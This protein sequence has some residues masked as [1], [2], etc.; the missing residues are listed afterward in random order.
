MKHDVLL[1]T[2][3]KKCNHGRPCVSVSQL[4]RFEIQCFASL[5]NHQQGLARQCV[6]GLPVPGR[7]DL[8]PCTSAAGPACQECCGIFAITS[9]HCI[10][11][12][13]QVHSCAAFAKGV[14][15]NAVIRSQARWCVFSASLQLSEHQ[16]VVNALPRWHA[17]CAVGTCFAHHPQRAR[18]LNAVPC[19][20]S[21]LLSLCQA[22]CLLA[23]AC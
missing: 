8:R 11:K 21:S 6:F 7:L 19:C 10:C 16:W 1:G 3:H 9:M 2:C 23:L 13:L 17:C 12:R 15:E 5:A 4:R 22:L 14:E 20:G 18:V